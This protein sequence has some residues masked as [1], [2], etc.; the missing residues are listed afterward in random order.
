VR[1]IQYA[2]ATLAAAAALMAASGCASNEV[3]S[4]S[5]AASQPSPASPTASRSKKEDSEANASRGLTPSTER[6]RIVDT[7]FE[8]EGITVAV[9]STIVWKQ[10]GLQ[11]HSVTAADETFDSS[12]NCSPIKTDKCLG[13][14]D[15]YRVEFTEPGSYD[16][17][18]RVH[19]LPDG[20]GMTGTITVEK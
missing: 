6:A 8:P 11:P 13:Q 2:L 3:G 5:G 19:G 4:G 14:G 10:I 12:P 20:T 9:G 17:Y 7:A 15:G 1:R 16:Y 18:C